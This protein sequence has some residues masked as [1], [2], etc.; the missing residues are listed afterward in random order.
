MHPHSRYDLFMSLSK[1]RSLLLQYAIANVVDTVGRGDSFA[2]AIAFGFL[3][4]MPAVNTLALEQSSR[5]S[6]A[7]KCRRGLFILG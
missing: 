6:E 4:H 1:T 2:V 3:Q 5:T 7:I